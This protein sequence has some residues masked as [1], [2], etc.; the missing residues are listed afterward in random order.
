MSYTAT[1]TG[2]VSSADDT[3]FTLTISTTE[4]GNGSYTITGVSG[5]FAGA[6]VSSLFPAPGTPDND[7][8]ASSDT[9][10]V[11]GGLDSN[12]VSIAASL[13]PAN[14][15]DNNGVLSYAW[16]TVNGTQTGT[17]TL[18]ASD[19]PCFLRGTR[20]AAEGGQVAVEDLT[21][22]MRVCTLRGALRPI[23]W[24]GRRRH[25]RHPL[26]GAS[27]HDISPI[28]IARDA[29]ADGMPSRDLL[30]SP[31]HSL[32][33]AGHL[34]NARHLVNGSTIAPVTTLRDVEYFHIELERHEVILAEDTPAETYLD[35]GNAAQ[36]D[37]A[38]ERP[39]GIAASAPAPLSA[40]YAPHAYGRSPVLR[41]VRE[42]LNAR[43]AQTLQ[44]AA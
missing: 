26:V 29:I 42:C 43:A 4:N 1:Y 14:I 18:V 24:I 8:Y 21:V 31:D 12:G 44:T 9:T 6:S 17:L 39:G 27:W 23:R 22:G 35:N 16:E 11:V 37:N 34:I 41:T 40:W 15:F 13:G 5:T 32:F 19:V 38:V 25:L 20:I 7:A 28:R 10:G 36:W 3:N 2:S 33:L 30:V